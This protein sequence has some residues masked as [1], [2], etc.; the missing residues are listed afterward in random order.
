MTKTSH[1]YVLAYI[2]LFVSLNYATA[3]EIPIVQL[4]EPTATIQIGAAAS[5]QEEFAAEEIQNFVLRFTQA[6][7]EIVT[8]REPTLTPTA[9]VLGTPTSNPTINF[10]LD[11]LDTDLGD[12]GYHIKAIE[13][14]NETIITIAAHTPRGVIYGAYALIEAC[15]T[16]LTG[17]SPVDLDFAVS[18]SS[19]LSLPFI[20]E[21]SRPF[22]PVRAVLEVDD[23]DWL[24]RHRINMSGAEGIWR[25]GGTDD[26]L[27][28]AFQY[29]DTPIFETLQDEP[30][31]QRQL[32]IQT[33]RD[34]FD[35]LNRRGIGVPGAARRTRISAN[36]QVMSN[37]ARGVEERRV[38]WR[39]S[40]TPH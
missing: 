37:K 21:K 9:I 11:E 34:R 23:P 18:P 15:I 19:N 36:L 14:D 29:V 8:N 5:V 13:L 10:L 22:Y 40:R 2:A 30:Q 7:L 28:T 31:A 3:A 38:M 20:D 1:L 35:S 32:L 6:Q 39:T 12:E 25:G 4:G 26:S 17:L 27:G 24:A 33:L 16:Q